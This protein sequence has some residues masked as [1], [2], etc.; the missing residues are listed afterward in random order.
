[1]FN[2]LF[3]GDRKLELIRGLVEQRMQDEGYSDVDS[4]L[5]TKGMGNVQ[6]T[7]TP[8]AAIVTILETVIKSQRQGALIGQ[9][10]LSI[11]NHRKTLGE[12]QSIFEKLMALACSSSEKAGDAIPMYVI[13][14]LNIEHPHSLDIE[15][16]TRAFGQAVQELTG[17]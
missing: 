9:I 3:G 4:R 12:D 16:I 6:L 5:K 13:Y 17:H 11:E 8:E 10:L 1:M 15:Q 14:R 2:F 7:S